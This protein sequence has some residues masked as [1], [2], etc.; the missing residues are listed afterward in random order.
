MD[1]DEL[2]ELLN[3]AAEALEHLHGTKWLRE[4]LIDELH[5]YAAWLRDTQKP[6]QEV[7]DETLRKL[8][9]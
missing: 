4:P 3:E 8:S 5:G 9:I 6:S 2:I 1:L 7:G